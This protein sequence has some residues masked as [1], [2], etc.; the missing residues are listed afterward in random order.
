MQTAK[1]HR[2]DQKIRIE[3]TI[4]G[5]LRSSPIDIRKQPRIIKASAKKSPSLGEEWRKVKSQ[6]ESPPNSKPT[7][8]LRPEKQTQGILERYLSKVEQ[9]DFKTDTPAFKIKHSEIIG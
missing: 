3:R 4:P 9:T 1:R 5:L 2:S 8:A 7:K 6:K